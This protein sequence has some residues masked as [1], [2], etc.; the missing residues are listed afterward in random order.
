MERQAVAKVEKVSTGNNHAHSQS[1]RTTGHSLL[2]LQRAV[3]NQAIQRLTNSP[4]IQAKLQ[5]SAPEDESEQEADRVADTVMRM[6]EGE[7]VAP[8]A[9]APVPV[10]VREDDEEEK[11]LVQ[12]ACDK[13]EEESE[14]MVQRESGTH[15]T[16]LKVTNS[17]A[18][19]INAMNGGGSPLPAT[20]RAFFEPRFGADFSQVRVHMDSH[21][22]STANSIQAKAFTV[23][24]NIAF[25]P[26]QYAPES[27]EGKQL[28]AHE[29]TH[30]V[31]Q[32][33]SKVQRARSQAPPIATSVARAITPPLIQRQPACPTQRDSDEVTKA[34]SPDGVL[35]A[36]T[37]FD[38][39][40]ESLSLQ[41]FGIDQPGVRPT[42]T[43]S[44]DWRRMMSMILGDP[45]VQVAVLG[46]SD[47][48]GPEQN[49]KGLRARRATAVI[50][51]M[52]AE[53]QA[54]VSPILKGWWGNLTYRFPNNT[55]ENRARNRM[56]LV[57]LLRAPTDSCDRLPKATNMDQY[58]FLVSCLEKRLGLT[59]AADAPKT[60]SLLRQIYFGNANWSTQRNRS[61]VWDDI[62]PDRAWSP[63]DDPT[64]KLGAKLLTALQDSKEVKF[65]SSATSM[66]IEVS[67]LLTGLDALRNPQQ[68][69]IH[70]VGPIHV[71]P[72]A[73]NH[74]ISTWAGDVASAAT[75]YT[76]C[77]D[78]GKVQASRDDFFKD[79][80]SDADLE[81]DIDTYAAWAA[82]NYNAPP[83]AVALQLNLP[84]S[85][86]LM[87][88]YRLKKPIAGQ[89]RAQRYEA[90]ANFYG[91]KVQGRKMQDRVAFKQNIN[92]AVSQLAF[93]T[94][95]KQLKEILQGN[96][97]SL[98]NCAG[99]KPPVP[100]GQP[101]PPA[102]LMTLIANVLANSDEMT[103]RFT[104][105]LEQ[106]L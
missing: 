98:G 68:P 36:D 70:A 9:K 102:D 71:V 7:I 30:V 90:F 10:A 24:T 104:V 95:A 48:M 84:V 76:L 99:G 38:A 66:S 67:H 31:Q 22:A 74:E 25:G 1:A 55:A 23:G 37:S 100:T 93:L 72:D 69:A 103:E 56:V 106:R 28:L 89:A 94:F 88:Y 8:K 59:S 65:D 14:E 43:D 101:A 4:F 12:R 33:G 16:T 41:D 17:V 97:S 27:G 58:I 77:V 34:Q 15:A 21:A 82:V 85:E 35:P 49:N 61:K 53:A 13:C 91:A 63:G 11:S 96:T 18:A 6:P 83:N 92:R 73:F 46:Y 87:Q 51:A 29:L 57:A 86:L 45:T 3:G 81:G 42:M 64:P 52:P 47:C 79:M 105:W 60:L 19:D 20:T 44:D 5:I 54:K 75:N 80:A 78:F 39:A 26:G 50:N 62:I 32:N 40:K 2:E